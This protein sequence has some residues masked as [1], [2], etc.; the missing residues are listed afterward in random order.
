LSAKELRFD[1]SDGSGRLVVAHQ[2]DTRKFARVPDYVVWW[3]VYRVTGACPGKLS[4]VS[5]TK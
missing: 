1:V 4:A 3:A 5:A 2:H